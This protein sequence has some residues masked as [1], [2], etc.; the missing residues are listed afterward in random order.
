LPG[1]LDPW[2]VPTEV[3]WPESEYQVDAMLPQWPAV[4][5]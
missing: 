5:K 2:V 3:V 1:K 4:R